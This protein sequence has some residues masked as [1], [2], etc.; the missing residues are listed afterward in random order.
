MSPRAKAVTTTVLELAG[1]LLLVLALVAWVLPYSAPG[2]LAVGGLG[3][4]GVSWAI[5]RPPRARRAPS[6]GERE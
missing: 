2:A 3:L 6:G 1:M 4:I 5:T